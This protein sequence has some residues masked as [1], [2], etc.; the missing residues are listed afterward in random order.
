MLG[1]ERVKAVDI[2]E[3]MNDESDSCGN[4]I[5]VTELYGLFDN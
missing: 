2:P 5:C 1:W 4:L 3:A